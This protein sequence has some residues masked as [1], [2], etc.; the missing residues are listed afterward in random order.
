VTAGPN[1]TAAD[2][3]AQ[4]VPEIQR[5]IDRELADPSGSKVLQA[6]IEVGDLSTPA[7]REQLTNAAK[8]LTNQVPGF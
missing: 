7:A 5:Q 2:T 6:E 1:A 3:A 4:W 8:A